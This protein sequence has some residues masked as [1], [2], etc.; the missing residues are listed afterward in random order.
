MILIKKNKEPKAWTEYRQTPGVDYQ[1]NSELV[2]ALLKEQG[3]ICA[4][5]M[6]RIPCKDKLYKS[7]GRDYV[8]TKEDHRIEHILCR[9][10]HDDKKLDYKNMVICCP[11]HIGDED[12]CD[13]LKG[14]N[15]ISFSPLDPTF[16]GTL[17]YKND[18]EILSAKPEFNEE[19]NK[20]QNL[21]TPLL[22]INRKTF[23]STVIN[24]IKQKQGEKPWTESV[25]NKYIQK[26]S[27]K[28]KDG[29][30]PPYCGIIL[31]YLKKK[32]VSLS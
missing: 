7:N 15:D 27:S 10:K 17:S 16:I 8:E 31:Y 20:V 12:H 13:R 19:I 1:P 25:I 30:L 23:H 4:Y 26:Y 28:D 2:D 24:M 22:K 18:G 3:Y 5:C 14:D 29:K 11:G 6:R 32:L 9:E 21:N